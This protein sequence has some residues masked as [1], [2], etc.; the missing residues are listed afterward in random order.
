M[1]I[2]LSVITD[3]QKSSTAGNRTKFPTKAMAYFQPHLH[4]IAILPCES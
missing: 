4:C 3:F 2:T 1:A